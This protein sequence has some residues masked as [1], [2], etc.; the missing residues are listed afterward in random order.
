MGRAGIYRLD[1]QNADPNMEWNSS[2]FIA[3]QSVR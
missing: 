2:I 3:P 1:T